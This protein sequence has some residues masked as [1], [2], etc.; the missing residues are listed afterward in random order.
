M[1]LLPT[2]FARVCFG[3]MPENAA[4]IEHALESL[5]KM[6][7]ARQVEME[8]RERICPEPAVPGNSASTAG[9]PIWCH[10]FLR[11]LH[12]NYAAASKH[13]ADIKESVSI[14]LFDRLEKLFARTVDSGLDTDTWHASMQIACTGNPLFVPIRHYKKTAADVLYPPGTPFLRSAY[15]AFV[16]ALA[17]HV[18]DS[19]V[20]LLIAYLRVHNFSEL[21][22][23]ERE[24]LSSIDIDVLVEE[25]TREFPTILL[26]EPESY[27]IIFVKYARGFVDSLDRKCTAICSKFFTAVKTKNA[28]EIDEC[29][30]SLELLK[31][32][33]FAVLDDLS[34]RLNLKT[35]AIRNLNSVC[36]SLSA[37]RQ[38]TENPP[39]P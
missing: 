7:A 15:C 34:G 19:R 32:S 18:R 24:F 35:A 11:L 13:I 17:P 1:F 20:A 8:S 30:S 28:A 33:V 14:K 39:L 27:S 26:I 2:L 4:Q 23:D 3:S 36:V 25:M 22:V 21:K 31:R 5:R 12:Q 16:F 9:E 10:D 29:R 38:S 37:A 6:S